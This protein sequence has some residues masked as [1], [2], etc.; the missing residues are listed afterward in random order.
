MCIFFIGIYKNLS[1]ETKLFKNILFN[2]Y[3]F[4][5]SSWI[6]ELIN[7]KSSFKFKLKGRKK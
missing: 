5:K 4:I 1:N 3:I 6:Q 2:K 7:R